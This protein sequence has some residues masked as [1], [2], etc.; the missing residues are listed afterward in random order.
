MK[1]TKSTNVPRIAPST[2]DVEQY[3]HISTLTSDAQI[4]CVAGARNGARSLPST[5]SYMNAAALEQAG[6]LVRALE[7]SYT[8]SNLC[9]VSQ[10]PPTSAF[11]PALE[12]MSRLRSLEEDH[13]GEG[14]SA[15]KED[16]V[17]C[18]LLFLQS[19][20]SYA[21]EPRVG[22][23]G[24]GN[25]VIEFHGDVGFGQVLFTGDDCVEMLFIPQDGRPVGIE[26]RASEPRLTS[27]LRRTL[28][29]S[30]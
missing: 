13:D 6:V 29:F 25:A 9:V 3:L 22:V 15:A 18:A 19:M 21:P 23:D 2:V 17:D 12:R 5:L 7:Q 14:G 10:L 20:P 11:G 26:A 1:M 24:D 30:V 28:G 8:P 16:A 4:S 27:A